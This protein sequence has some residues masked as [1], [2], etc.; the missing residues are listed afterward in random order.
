MANSTD[1]I[2]RGGKYFI[3]YH[4]FEGQGGYPA[5]EILHEEK[6]RVLSRANHT[7]SSSRPTILYTPGNTIFLILGI[8]VKKKKKYYLWTETIVDE[9]REGY[10]EKMYDVQGPQSFMYLP[11]LLN[12]EPGFSDFRNKA[13]NFGLGVQEIT[14]WEFLKVLIRLRDTFR[15]KN[16]NVLTYR[17]YIEEFENSL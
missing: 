5:D 4:N 12:E 11:P 3:A 9:L 16:Q 14:N 8:N 10:S 15:C 6:N 13:G 17:Q 1:L 7:I 2:N